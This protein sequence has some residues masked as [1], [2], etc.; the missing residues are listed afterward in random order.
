M[1]AS[2]KVQT[3]HIFAIA[4]GRV[5]GKRQNLLIVDKQGLSRVLSRGLG[6]A[7]CKQ[8]QHWFRNSHPVGVCSHLWWVPEPL[9]VFVEMFGALCGPQIGWLRNFAKRNILA[10]FQN[11]VYTKFATS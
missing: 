5:S 1:A 6:Y 7:L 11:F 8:I 4:Y 2:A 3:G 9:L 10:N